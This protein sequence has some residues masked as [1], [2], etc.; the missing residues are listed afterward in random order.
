MS[1][2]AYPAEKRQLKPQLPPDLMDNYDNFFAMPAGTDPCG[3]RGVVRG[4]Q[5]EVTVRGHTKQSRQTEQSKPVPALCSESR[6][7]HTVHARFDRMRLYTGRQHGDR[8]PL[9]HEAFTDQR[10]VLLDPSHIGVVAFEDDENI[11]YYSP[12]STLESGRIFQRHFSRN[13]IV[14]TFSELVTEE[15]VF[16]LTIDKYST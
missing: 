9:P 11:Q 1:C 7:G 4:R 14:L 13:L 2:F 12:V 6:D 8:M 5:D 15:G 16:R 3:K 10:K